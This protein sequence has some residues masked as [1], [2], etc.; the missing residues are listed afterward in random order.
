MIH[1]LTSTDFGDIIRVVNEAALAYKGVI[2]ADR[3]N[4]PYM[5]AVELRE[6]IAAGVEFYG[7]EENR[8]IIAV[9]GIQTVRDLTLIRHA[10]VLTRHQR[11]GI[12]AKLL[13]QLLALAVTP[14][15]L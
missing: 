10:Y 3:W 4:E 1:K 6:E 9:M 11:R 13:R 5:P 15:V 7:Y 8:E 2:P 12:G 14:V